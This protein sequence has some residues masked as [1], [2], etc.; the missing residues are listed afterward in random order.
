MSELT[1]SRRILAYGLSCAD[2]DR[3]LADRTIAPLLLPNLARRR[4]QGRLSRRFAFSD[5]CYVHISTSR[6]IVRVGLL[7]SRDSRKA[8]S[9]GFGVFFL[10]DDRLHADLCAASALAL[11]KSGFQIPGEAATAI[12]L[13]MIGQIGFTTAIHG[14][15]AEPT[16]CDSSRPAFSSRS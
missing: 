9:L 15:T 4:T 14:A 2:A 12:A 6:F 7:R 1:L 11:G 13:H 5:F 8:F 3:V 10:L 16:G